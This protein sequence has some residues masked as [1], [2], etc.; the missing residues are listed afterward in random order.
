MMNEDTVQRVLETIDRLEAHVTSKK[1]LDILW[2]DTKNI[3]VDEI[4]KLPNKQLS[5]D[6]KQNRKIFKGKAFWN[7]EF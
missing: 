1:E 3:I 7:Q 2:A 6:S 4:K 5:N